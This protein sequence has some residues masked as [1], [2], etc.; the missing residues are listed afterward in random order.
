MDSRTELSYQQDAK[1]VFSPMEIT[2]HGK[3]NLGSTPLGLEMQKALGELCEEYDYIFSL[4]QGDTGH[5]R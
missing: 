2:N 4:H 5:T 1:L 3:I